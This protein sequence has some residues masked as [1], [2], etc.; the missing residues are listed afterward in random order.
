MTAQNGAAVF[1][2]PITAGK[3]FVRAHDDLELNEPVNVEYA[4]ELNVS[5]GSIEV[6]GT[7]AAH[8]LEA[9]AAGA[10]SDIILGKDV[11]VAED[12]TLAASR[13]VIMLSP[14][15]GGTLTASAGR[16]AKFDGA[17]DADG[18]VT[19]DAGE[20]L[21]TAELKSNADVTLDAGGSIAVNGALKGN[22]VKLSSGTNVKVKG[23]TTTETLR[24]ESGSDTMLGDVK[25]ATVTARAGSSITTGAVTAQQTVDMAASRDIIVDGTL[26]GAAVTLDA[27]RNITVNGTAIVG[28]LAIT[29]GANTTLSDVDA[30][31]LTANAGGSLTV[32]KLTAV[33]ADLSAKNNV[34]TAAVSADELTVDAGGTLTTKAVTARRAILDTSAD[35]IVEGPLTGGEFA[36]T[37]GSD[38]TVKDTTTAEVLNVTSGA[39]TKLA[40][41]DAETL[42]ANAGGS[43][44]IGNITANEAVL[45]S[46]DDLTTK[47]VSVGKLDMNAGG[48]LTTASVMAENVSLDA[49]SDI[50]VGGSLTADDPQLTAGENV[51]VKGTATADALTVNAGKNVTLARTIVPTV[52]VNAGRHVSMEDRG[53]DMEVLNLSADSASVYDT[54]ALKLDAP[55][56]GDLNADAAGALTASVAHK[57]RN[58]TLTSSGASVDVT[59]DLN[60]DNVTVN[61]KE[62][63]EILRR[64]TVTNTARFT[65]SA[66]VTVSGSVKSEHIST[67]SGGE[68]TLAGA[69]ETVDLTSVAGGRILVSDR[70]K[71]SGD[72]AL[73]SRNAGVTVEEDIRARNLLISA[74]E[75]IAPAHGIFVTDSTTLRTSGDIALNGEVQSGTLTTVSGGNTDMGGSVKAREITASAAGSITTVGLTADE[76]SLTASRDVAVRGALNGGDFTLKSQNAG[77]MLDGPATVRNLTASAGENLTVNGAIEARGDVELEA[78]GSAALNADALAGRD[79]S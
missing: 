70:V 8:E 9:V 34:T 44:A 64:V 13:D 31:D 61:A 17:I 16:S 33:S 57:A 20:D 30:Y 35:I 23:T 41:V 71:A 5:A 62:A 38:I 36:L 12:L 59:T 29:S 43:I 4:A 2:G 67:E 1:D 76:A 66:D 27:G 50:I 15:A 40:D 79:L 60:A 72:I 10:S 21:T 53:N 45:N 78:E 32:G 65:S 52:D 55:R 49:G 26:N 54:N 47:D 42:T 69:I 56:I 28:A 22:E 3:L 63:L 46:S 25:A 51:T 75:T 58:V 24:A 37:A 68:T 18:A 48:S 11:K 6:R 39:D 7:F 73:I 14:F 77:V 74:R 19:V